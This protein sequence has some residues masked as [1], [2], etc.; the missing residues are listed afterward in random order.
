[1]L[2][3]L[4]ATAFALTMPM[5]VQANNVSPEIVFGSGN[6]NGSFT[7]TTVEFP[8]T[9]PPGSIELAL[10]AKLRYDD[11]LGC[12][13]GTEGCPKNIFNWDGDHTYTFAPTIGTPS[14]RSVFNFEWSIFSDG[15]GS[16][17]SLN[18][19]SAGVLLEFDIDPSENT[20]FVGYDPLAFDAWYGT[21][22]TPNGG[23]TYV[24]NTFPPGAS[25]PLAGATVAQ[26]SVNYGFLA[27]APLGQG[28]YNVR[29]SLLNNSGIVRGSTEIKISV[30]PVPAALPL[31]LLALGG[32]AWY[33]RRQRKA[34]AA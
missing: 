15:M 20:D 5:A 21:D 7:I 9:D 3:L 17:K 32:L 4:T 14:N 27:G 1:M 19:G 2:R 34:Q 25:M 22:S 29:L 10:R 18:T 16:I 11:T 8:N 23:G 6:A 13:G 28:T 31:G 24:P 26:N 30:V 12:K 33:G